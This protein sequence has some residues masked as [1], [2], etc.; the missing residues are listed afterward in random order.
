MRMSIRTTSGRVPPDDV[1]RAARRRAASPT[2]WMSGSAS[3]ITR[4]PV[5]SSRWSSAIDDRDLP[6]RARP[7]APR[8]VV[9][10]ASAP[11]RRDALGD[12]RSR[13]APAGCISS[14]TRGPAIW[15]TTSEARISPGRGGVAEAA[16]D[17][18]RRPVEVVAVGERLAGVEAD[19][20][21][22]AASAP[23]VA[24]CI[25]TAQRTAATALE[26][27]T[28]S[29]SPV[30]LHLAAVVLGDHARAASAKSVAARRRPLVADAVEQRRRA[31][32]VGEQDR[33]ER[34]STAR[35][36]IAGSRA[37]RHP[38]G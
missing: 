30:D 3:R 33:D 8:S 15:R 19:R 9:L 16:G 4:K 1:D 32:E 25:A 11:A 18:H 17:D 35:S 34:A 38:S 13:S 10:A 37:A 24:R 28:I 12:A 6:A 27:A 31:D 5:R 23:V 22:A 21:S 20:A 36:I 26:K 2:T 29:P 7:A 14:A